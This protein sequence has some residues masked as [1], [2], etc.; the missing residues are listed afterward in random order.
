MD[1][2][3]RLKTF[4]D[5][6]G[7]PVTQFADNCGIPRPTLSQLLNGR[8]KTVRD[9]LVAKIHA[10]YPR[11]S[12][13]WLLFGEGE[14]ILDAPEAATAS[15]PQVHTPGTVRF[16]GDDTAGLFDDPE[17]Q[18]GQ[19]SHAT[20]PQAQTPIDFSF[21]IPQHDNGANLTPAEAAAEHN[22]SD[23]D[24]GRT[25]AIINNPATQHEHSPEHRQDTVA[26]PAAGQ[27]RVVS[28]IVYYNDSSYQAFVPDDD[29]P[30]SLPFPT[31]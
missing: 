29:N 20:S 21:D 19:N 8:N 5:Y 22:R 17:D 31:R 7:V 23:V 12:V 13:M 24:A 2:V 25:N 18:P 1:I 30:A 14:A 26:E 11:L 10:A 3:S 27:R 15:R 16:H 4:I 6:L 9:E 28:I